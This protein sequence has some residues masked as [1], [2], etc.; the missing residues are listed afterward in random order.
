M[1]STDGSHRPERATMKNHRDKRRDIARSILP[2]STSVKVERRL[3]QHRERAWVRTQLHRMRTSVDIDD[4]P[5]REWG[6][7]LS[8]QAWMVENRRDHDKD[9]ALL[10]WGQHH[11][12]SNP[13]LSNGTTA[14]R[15]AFF[16][17][18]LPAGLVGDHAL[19][20]VGRAIDDGRQIRWWTVR[21]AHTAIDTTRA[22]T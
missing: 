17:S 7:T 16:R 4:D 19:S 1:P 2:S 22:V 21:P 18:V 8:S 14:D 10:R 3:I 6:V 20:H 15:A 12:D 11:I 9:A 5:G 13:A